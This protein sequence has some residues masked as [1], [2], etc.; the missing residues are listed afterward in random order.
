MR[1]LWYAGASTA[2]AVG[3]TTYA[4]QQRANFYSAMVYLSQNNLS[5]MILINV[6]L[7]MYGTFVYSLQRLCYGQLRPTEVEQLYEKAWFAVTE[8]CLAMTI[9]R[10][11]VGAWFLVMFTALV[12]GKIWQWIG[13]GRVEV[14]EQQPPANPRLFHT[15]L[16]ISLIFSILYD[17]WLFAYAVNTVIQQARPNMMVMFLFEFAILTTDSF[18]TALRYVLSLVETSI[19]KKQTQQRLE[20]RRKQVRDQR[21]EILRLRVSSD[22]AEAEA[23]NQQELPDEEDIDEMDIEVPGWETK[24]QWILSLELVADFVKLGVYAAFFAVLM[25][26]YGLPIHIMRDL[27]MTTRSFLKRLSALIRYRKALQ[28]MNKY[29]DATEEELGRENTCIICREDMRPW[30]PNVTGAVERSRP[31]K[32]PCGHILHFGCLKSWLER[33]QVCPTCRRSVVMDG[34]MPNG[35]AAAPN[36]G[37]QQPAPGQPGANN[38]AANGNQGGQGRPGGM[39]MFQLGPLRLGFAQGNPQNLQEIA[40]RFGMPLDGVNAPAPAVNPAGAG[41]PVPM[42]APAVPQPPHEATANTDRANDMAAQLQ[43]IAQRL[44]Q[45]MQSLQATQAE[46]QT[47]YAMRAELNRLRQLQHH[48]SSMHVPAQNDANHGIPNLQVPFPA[49]MPAHQPLASFPIM[50]QMA[51]FQYPPRI[52]TPSVTRHAAGSWSTTIPAGSPDLPEGVVIPQ[53]WTLMPLQRIDPQAQPS[54]AQMPIPQTE[55]VEVSQQGANLGTAGAASASGEIPRSTSTGPSTSQTQQETSSA[56]SAE[57][58]QGGAEPPIVAAPQPVAPNWGGAAQLFSNNTPSTSSLFP[59]SNTDHSSRPNST[60][61]GHSD[62]EQQHQGSSP[63]SS[64]KGKAKAVTVEDAE[65]AED[66]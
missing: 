30:D 64:N 65:D 51:Q 4:F 26:F 46:L 22:A 34:G 59:G 13:E 62:N 3:V 27:F 6:I 42:A 14:L 43:D 41:V 28:D 57:Q 66:E 56:T 38:G 47:L 53:G 8:T 18:R 55:T 31:K 29:P 9:F 36:A 58:S 20:E 48:T 45:E 17:T 24:G 15:R 5:L 39:R 40:Q 60:D 19:T 63:E 25:M 61:G 52:G 10:E 23:A 16:S 44:H 32:L 11:E 1:I 21:T 54:T 7:L 12:T 33:Q 49:Q 37:G 50:P 2:L 35:H